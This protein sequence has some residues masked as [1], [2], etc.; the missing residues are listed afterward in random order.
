MRSAVARFYLL[1][2]PILEGRLTPGKFKPE[3]AAFA[4]CGFDADGTA[5]RLH[6]A[7]RKRETE[8]GSLD[9]RL[10]GTKTLERCKQP[11]EFFIRNSRP[12]V[13]HTNPDVLIAVSVM[14]ATDGFCNGR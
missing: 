4:H 11:L 1:Q 6:Q 10:F 12:G 2:R 8:A 14:R 13:M 3:G 9:V 7:L 5:H